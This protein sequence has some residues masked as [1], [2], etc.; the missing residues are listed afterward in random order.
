MS[1]DRPATCKY[2]DIIRIQDMLDT[3]ASSSKCL[4][5]CIILHVKGYTRYKFAFVHS[6]QVVPPTDSSCT[7]A[8]V[9]RLQ[10]RADQEVGCC[11]AAVQGGDE[12]Q[13]V[14]AHPWLSDEGASK[15]IAITCPI[16]RLEANIPT[17]R[18][19]GW[20]LQNM[21]H[22]VHIPLSQ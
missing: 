14:I 9:I 19:T 5:A 6:R 8:K 16:S 21:S 2:R 12:H 15:S 3:E 10:V 1:I 11:R 20:Q 13:L 17:T 7:K 4:D 18:L 22:R